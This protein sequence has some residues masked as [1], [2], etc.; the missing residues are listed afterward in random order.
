[1]KR[2]LL[3]TALVLG[4]AVLFAQNYD[5][6][7]VKRLMNFLQQPS[8]K[9]DTNAA[10]LEIPSINSPSTWKGVTWENGHVATIKWDNKD[11]A[12]MLDVSGF[13]GLTSID[14]SRNQLT[15]ILLTS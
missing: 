13:S 5:K 15:A 6:G 4:S 10:R 7:E 12:G 14:C 11:L 3:T 1:M 9:G 2:L 8:A